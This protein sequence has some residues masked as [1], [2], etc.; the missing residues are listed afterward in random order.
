MI[1]TEPTEAHQQ[2][3]GTLDHPS[4]GKGM[5]PLG[6]ELVPVYLLAFGHQDAPF[7]DR[8]RL[9]RLHL[10]AHVD[11]HPR[12]KM[13]TVMAIAPHQNHAREAVCERGE[14]GTRSLLIG[15]MGSRHFHGQQMADA[16]STSTWRLR[17]EI[18]FPHV[19]ALFRTANGAGFDR[20]AE[21]GGGA[22]V[23]VSAFL[24]AHLH[25]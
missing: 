16:V 2:A 1:A 12:H 22:G 20:L 3:E 9:D 10:P 15:A 8:E 5:E 18:F 14:Q 11:L 19:N 25:P 7:G 23:R 6:E 4:S 13:S 21:G 17:P 24:H